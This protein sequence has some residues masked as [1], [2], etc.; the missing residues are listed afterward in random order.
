[1]M[2]GAWGLEIDKGRIGLCQIRQTSDGLQLKRGASLS[3]PPELLTPSPTESNVADEEE[4]ASQ[5]RNLVKEVGWRGGPVVL[6]LP[7]LTCR[8]GFQD[9]DE[10][11]G[12]PSETRQLLS[13][14]LKDRLPFPAQEARI[15]YQ[16]LP[17]QENRSRLL[18]LVAREAV[19]AQ[20]ETLLAKVGL[21]PIRVTTRGA[22]LYRLHQF[23]HI[24][25]K[26][27]FLAYGP[28]SIVLAYAEREIPRLWRTLPWKGL[29]DP[30]DG[31]HHAQKV[32]REI[33]ETL[34]YLRDEMK[35]ETPEHLCLIGGSDTSLAESLASA[36]QLPVCAHHESQDGVPTDLLVPAGAA[37]LQR[38]WRLGWRS[39]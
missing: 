36:G 7:D 33:H 8:I 37:L 39:R 31:N 3:P 1:M 26:R 25:D 15:D 22:A 20:Y 13:W 21:D 9:F 16:A 28:S 19:I 29:R 17:S 38:T 14:R 32:V 12:T 4:F 30:H 24:S 2:A 10:L 23:V 27:L 5:L 6:A 18:Y 35:V 34:G 11:Q